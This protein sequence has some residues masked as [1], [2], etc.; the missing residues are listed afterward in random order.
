MKSCG[1]W[2]SIDWMKS[3][4]IKS[5]TY[6]GTIGGGHWSDLGFLFLSIMWFSTIQ[7]NPQAAVLIFDSFPKDQ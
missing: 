5:M 4:I 6:V 1:F 2:D 7:V 3:K